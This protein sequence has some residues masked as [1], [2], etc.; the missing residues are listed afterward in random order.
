[1]IDR[2]ISRQTPEATTSG[3]KTEYCRASA[4]STVAARIQSCAIL[5]M[6]SMINRACHTAAWPAFA[7]GLVNSTSDLYWRSGSAD[8]PD[9]S[10]TCLD[11]DG[12]EWSRWWTIKN[13]SIGRIERTLMTRTF[14]TLMIARVI[15]GTTQMCALLPVSVKSTVWC[16][17]KDCRITHRRVI[18]IQTAVRRETFSALD[19]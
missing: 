5:I 6:T 12:V 13:I 17:H 19:E 3:S 9:L 7:R 15:D 10:V 18:E 14:Q 11:F 2:V 8:G 16:A 4:A 1:M